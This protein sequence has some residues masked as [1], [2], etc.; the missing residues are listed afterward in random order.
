MKNMTRCVL[1]CVAA[2]AAPVTDGGQEPPGVAGVDV[3]VKQMPSRRDVTNGFGIFALD[4]LP[5]GSY[6]LCFKA[7]PANKSRGLTSDK[8]VVATVYSITID[9]TKKQVKQD[10]LTSDKLVAG[11]DI[12]VQVGAGAKVRGQVLPGATKKMVWIP[13]TP[14]THLP[15]HWAEEGSKEVPRFHTEIYGPDHWQAGGR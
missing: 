6:T 8:V 9:G 12:T 11:V 5:A 2:L 13:P 15:G 7:R 1:L 4:P 10:G 14:G 3:F